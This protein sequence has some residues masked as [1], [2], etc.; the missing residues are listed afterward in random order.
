MKGVQSASMLYQNTVTD[1][2]HKV[3]R[4]V[5][6]R[7]QLKMMRYVGLKIP[8]KFLCPIQVRGTDYVLASRTLCH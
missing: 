1:V 3:G 7:E 6:G 2:K 4:G 8:E 5:G